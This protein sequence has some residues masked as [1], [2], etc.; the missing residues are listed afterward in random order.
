MSVASSTTVATTGYTPRERKRIMAAAS[1]GWG[2][3]FFDLM[4]VSLL[5]APIASHFGVS[6]A[7]MSIV[8]TAQLIATA[9]GG[10]F[11]GRLADVYG[12]KRVLTWTIWVFGL[13]TVACAFAPSFL[14]FVLLRIVTGFGVGGEWAVGFS[15]LNEAWNPKRRGLAGGAVQAAVWFG[16][17]AAIAVTGAVGDNWRVAFLVGGL[18]VLAAIWIRV[19]CPESHQWLA[20]HQGQVGSGSDPGASS[21]D[22]AA[23]PGG[24]RRLLDP[25]NLPVVIIGTLVVLGGQYSYYVYSSWMPTYLKA[26]LGVTPG[27]AQQILYASAA[28][29][30]VSYLVSGG[31]SDYVGRRPSLIAFALIQLVGFGMFVIFNMQGAS[32]SLIVLSYFVISFGLGYFGIFG[33]WLGELFPTPIRATASSFAY[34]IGRGIASFGPFIVGVLAADYGLAGGISTGAV[35]VLVMIGFSFFLKDQ[36]G[37]EITATT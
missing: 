24:L 14:V 15:L 33:A 28:I 26:D 19:G 22:A 11:F 12:R 30:L 35:A 32:V 1:L 18:P 25:E 4:L 29:A 17:A 9:V 5:V 16:Y 7:E 6:I 8:F 31:L 20:M 3:E 23:E 2:L 13:A 36:K 27:D 21:P 34:S 37:R 10:V